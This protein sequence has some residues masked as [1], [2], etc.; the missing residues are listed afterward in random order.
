MP[1]PGRSGSA[2]CHG[3]VEGMTR[4]VWMKTGALAVAAG[5][6]MAVLSGCGATQ[7]AAP[8]V[9]SAPETHPAPELTTADVERFL[10]GYLPA[11]LNT[12]KI[13]GATV[14]VVKDGKVVTTR[15]YGY[16][17]VDKGIPVTEDT[18]F[19][20]GS[21]SKI[22]TSIAA[23]QLV[24]QD[25]LDLDADISTYV[26]IPVER[27]FDAP[28][29]LRHL[30]T[31]TAGFEER[32]HNVLSVEKTTYDLQQDV[33][34][35]P[36]A[37]VYEPGSVVAYSNYGMA[38]IG[39][40]VQQVSGIPFEQYV[41]D[42]VLRPAGMTRS[43]YAQP[44]PE[45]LAGEFS[46]G[47]VQAYEPA[48][49][50][51]TLNMPAG[52]MTASAKDFAQFMIAQLQGTL[53]RPDTM[54]M[55][56]SP[57]G[58]GESFS[59]N[60]P[61]MGLGF[62]MEDRNG[63][64]TVGHGGDTSAYHSWYSLFPESNT[65]IFVS[66]NSTGDKGSAFKLRMDFVQAFADRYLPRTQPLSAAPADTATRAKHIAGT[67]ASSRRFHTNYVAL[68]HTL[69][70]STKQ[71]SVNADGSLTVD[72]G[73]LIVSRYTE[74]EP[75]VWRQ[76]GG[77]GVIRADL[78]GEQVVLRG[79]SISEDTPATVAHRVSLP[80]SAA[81]ILMLVLALVAWPAGAIR[82]FL[83]R[84]RGRGN[85]APLGWVARSARIGGIVALI[86]TA[87]WYRTVAALLDQPPI[88]LTIMQYV[89]LIA[90]LPAGLSLI[91]AIRTR[92]GWGRILV[93]A[94]LL[95]GLVGIAIWAFMNNLLMWDFS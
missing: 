11:A 10:D 80:L 25:K 17:D 6:S 56:W 38:V 49:A 91:K 70:G 81:S 65:G 77:S 67:Y 45:D 73:G 27:K 76:V 58:S 89:G 93:A 46:L 88:I 26:D 51:E 35:D 36:P 12:A 50:F 37:Q 8:V 23:L 47:Y 15:G 61:T 9:A 1:S 63:H 48:P 52:S 85:G 69:P 68:T 95:G 94:L 44:L 24:E 41:Q 75:W 84:R 86:A 21:I 18:L 30:L 16:A 92:S 55:A 43:T 33:M 66:L 57:R 34:Y 5:L 64:Q 22:G 32:L 4:K 79:D 82:Q 87:G 13:P 83:A 31:H 14:A 72:I 59:P 20:V 40:I 7:E 90:V 54:A 28:I 3:K 39:Y 71:V 2:G 78:T 19:R 53:L 60:H 62:M 29:T 74:I 42:N